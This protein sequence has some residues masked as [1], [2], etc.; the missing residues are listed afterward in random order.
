MRDKTIIKFFRENLGIV[1]MML[2]IATY[3]Y[4]Q[5]ARNPARNIE[6]KT[7]FASI[8]VEGL[9]VTGNPGFIEFVTHDTNDNEVQYYLWVDETGDLRIASYSELSAYASFPTGDW[10]ITNMPV[11]TV[12]GTQS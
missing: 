6:G 9:A 4:A 12:V 11:G 3:C 2:I 8:G 5:A 10:D 1:L 7:N